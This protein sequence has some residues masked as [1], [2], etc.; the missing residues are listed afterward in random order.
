MAAAIEL[1]RVTPGDLADVEA[2]LTRSD[3]PVAGVREAFDDFVIARAGDE[4]VGVAGLEIGG[5]DAL[6][7]SVAVVPEWRS[8]GVGRALVTRII[9]DAEARG[10]RALYLLTTSAEQ[11]FPT[12]GFRPMARDAVPDDVKLT[13]E[14]LGVRCASAAV[15]C[16]P[17]GDRADSPR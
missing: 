14:F 10:I 15:M 16:L 12:F 13:S 7:R 4:V 9:G 17:L 3:L 5:R 2:L 8:H 11:Y 6:L 1:R